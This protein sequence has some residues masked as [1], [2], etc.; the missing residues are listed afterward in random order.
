MTKIWKTAPL[1]AL[2][3]AGSAQ[4]Q[5]FSDDFEGFTAG[6]YLAANSATWR[7]WTNTANI[8]VDV[9]IVTD[10]V[11]SG[12]N[13]IYFVTSSDGGGPDDIV[14]PF[15]GIYNTGTMAFETWIRVESGKGAYFNIQGD[16]PE[17]T[18]WAM[19]CQIDENGGLVISSNG[20]TKATSTITQDTWFKLNI[21]MDLNTNSWEAKI[22]DASIGTWT[23]NTYQI[24]SINLY[25]VNPGNNQAGY[26]ID[27]I[28]YNYTAYTPTSLNA[29]ITNIMM[30]ANLVGASEFPT[31][32]VRNL[33]T[34][35]ITSFDLQIDY[36]GGTIN[37]S[38]T[39]E[40]IAQNGTIEIVMDDELTLALGS[41]DMVATISNVNGGTDDFAG[42]DVKTVNFDPIAPA[43]GK[44][45]VGEEATGTWCGWCPRGAVALDFMED[46]YSDFFIGIAVHNNDPMVYEPYDTGFLSIHG[47]GY[48]SGAV[49]RITDIDPG[50]FESNFLNQI[51][52]PTVLTLEA[53]A[54][55]NTT[56]DSLYISFSTEFID[57]ASG[58]YKMAL[59]IVEDGITGTESGYAQS[60]Y[61]SGGGSGEMGGYETLPNPVPANQMVY[62]HV[63]RLISPSYAGHPNTYPATV[64]NG[65]TF[66]HTFKIAIDPTWDMNEISIVGMVMAP[67]GQIENAT[68]EHL[69][70]AIA[71]GFV[72]GENIVGL[73]KMEAPETNISLYPNP[74]NDQTT[75]SFESSSN[76]AINLVIVNVDGKI[77]YT[78]KKAVNNGV[79]EFEVNTSGFAKGMYSVKIEQGQ[80]MAVR[81]LVI[82]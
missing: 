9:Q 10:Q 26:W 36:D 41:N 5:T 69:N 27:D 22:D 78:N 31:V 62:D 30:G 39:G 43:V 35:T 71:N 32:E 8:D 64:T 37:K 19:D 48:P 11:H 55:Y 17:G 1:F 23:N 20:D 80:S 65:E 16:E 3:L 47:G 21:D 49:D 52:T 7:T 68:K 28:S 79:N 63:G 66:I 12:S 82:E 60:N 46:T 15:G 73:V 34:T 4:A 53:G 50:A 13:S 25:P 72:D 81:K 18:F 56:N 75:I 59:V 45:V 38:V 57:D 67:N 61:Y 77:V 33:G 44:M 58:N 14:L 70:D 2:L 54:Q 24:A 42:D 51:T 74:A 40:N 76:E 29:S 6:D